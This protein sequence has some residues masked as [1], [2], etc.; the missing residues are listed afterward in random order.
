MNPLSNSQPLGSERA[1]SYVH[2]ESI[3]QGT[4]EVRSRVRLCLLDTLAAIT[5]GHHTEGSQTVTQYALKTFAN[6]ETTILDGNHR[7][8]KTEG[9]VFANGIAANALDIDEGHIGAD[10]HPAAIVVP[11]AIAAAE[12]EGATI[13]E[14]LDAVLVGYEIA[15]RTGIA[16][17]A[18]TGHHTGTGSWGA[19]GAAAAAAKLRQ[20]ANKATAQALSI[21]EFSAPQTPILRSVATPGSGLTKDGIGWG[22]YVGITAIALAEQGLEGSGTLFDEPEI[23]VLEDIG[24]EYTITESYYKPYPCC[25]WIHPGID[26]VRALQEAYDIDIDNITE[27]RVHT[28]RNGVELGTRQPESTDAAEYSYPFAL[29]TTIVNGTFTPS[30]LKQPTL[31]NGRISTI[32]EK[33]KLVYEE[34]LEDRYEEAWLAWVEIETSSDTYTSEITHPRGSKERP[35]TKKEHHEKQ[36]M[37]LDP[38]LGDGTAETLRELIS[39]PKT[40]IEEL[41]SCWE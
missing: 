40:S 35:M 36:R 31:S 23:D 9:A 18:T 20:S 37:L 29:A 19:V 25:R 16:L 12:E 7:Q 39:K 38:Y 34:S 4:E 10:G 30:H 13:E 6:G 1:V 2:S 5:A 26:A 3:D 41:L 17:P 33:I 27:V 11:A 14:L 22:T 32:S 15:V 8:C 28:F 21:A 24:K